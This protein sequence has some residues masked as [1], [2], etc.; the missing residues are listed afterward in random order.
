MASVRGN[1]GLLPIRLDQGAPRRIS[2]RARLMRF[3]LRRMFKEALRF[4]VPVQAVRAR[5]EKMAKRLPPVP[6]DISVVDTVADGVPGHW[7]TPAEAAED[8]HILYLHGGGYVICSPR[9]HLGFT[10]RIAREARAR[11]LVIDYRLAPDHAFPAQIDDCLVAYR[12]LLDRGIDP[13]RI[14]VVGDSAG[15][16]LTF[17]LLMRLK[18]LGLPM[19]G[20]AVGLS[21]YLDLTATGESHFLNAKADPMIPLS[22]VLFGA[23]AYLQGADPRH[24]EASPIYGDAAGLPPCLIHVGSDEILLSDST[25]MAAKLRAAGVP[26]QIDIWHR[27]PHVWHAF[28]RY[29]PEGRAAIAEVGAFLRRTIR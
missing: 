24:P 8:R 15:G 1:A 17:G 3:A 13:K 12:H 9:T 2:L 21:P 25:R 11:M 10:W 26:V 14:A 19:P 16:G 29:I 4:D 22:G 6:A 7:I 5:T 20:A 18:A 27:M 23:M 28:A